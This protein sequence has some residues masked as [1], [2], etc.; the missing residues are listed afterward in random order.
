MSQKITV[1]ATFG[2]DVPVYS[3]VDVELDADLLQDQQA[4]REVL[5][6]LAHKVVEDDATQFTPDWDQTYSLRIVSVDREVDGR[7]QVFM[8]DEGIPFCP[9][10]LDA[11]QAL[12]VFSKDDNP[13][14]LVDAF[15]FLGKSED[16]ARAILERLNGKPRIVVT[17]SGGTVELMS[18]QSVDA[19]IVDYDCEG[20]GEDEG[21]KMV[22]QIH[23]DPDQPALVRQE[24]VLPSPQEVMDRY[25]SILEDA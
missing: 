12:D 3:S 2:M 10:F 20:F 13:E 11:G 7:S 8:E 25:F 17:V 23:P 21:V 5:I 1:T 19:M 24:S 16:E 15:R 4:L 6:P 18:T 22:P 9:R 14:A